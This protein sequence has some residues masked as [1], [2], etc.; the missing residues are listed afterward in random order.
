MSS[1]EAVIVVGSKKPRDEGGG[2]RE[3]R[4][5]SERDTRRNTHSLISCGFR[6]P[7]CVDFTSQTTMY[8][9]LDLKAMV[10]SRLDR[11]IL[12][13][14]DTEAQATMSTPQRLD[15][16]RPKRTPGGTPRR[17][18]PSSAAAPAYGVSSRNSLVKTPSPAGSS[19]TLDG[20]R[21]ASQQL[22]SSSPL[23]RS[24]LSTA[25]NAP[26]PVSLTSLDS[27]AKNSSPL[28]RS[29]L[30][31]H[32]QLLSPSTT[33]TTNNNNNNNNNNNRAYSRTTASP[34]HETTEP[35]PPPSSSRNNDDDD[36]VTQVPE[37]AELDEEMQ[38]AIQAV[39]QAHSSKISGLR[40][41]L[42]SADHGSSMAMHLLHAE[43]KLLQD[44]I[45]ADQAEID[46]LKKHNSKL[47]IQLSQSN[48]QGTNLP[49]GSILD[50]LSSTN[51]L[52]LRR[53][54]RT[55]APASRL[56]LLHLLLEAA[57]P[58]D[59]AAL[60]KY[61]EKIERS[62]RD[63]IGYLPDD[64]AVRC[65]LHLDLHSILRARLVSHRWNDVVTQSGLKLWRALALALT[66]K[67][68]EPPKPQQNTT[69]GWFELY[70]GLHY[71]EENWRKG[72][73]QRVVV[74][75]GH[76]GSIGAIKL[77]G[78]TLAT[79]SLD[80][81]LRIWNVR[82]SACLKIVKMPAPVS[83]LDFYG[84]YGPTGVI[85]AG[86]NDVGR[87]FLISMNGALLS[88]LSGHNKGI[89][90]LAMNSQYLVS[91]G[92]DKALVVW[93]W[94][95]GTRIVKFGQ[96][97]NPCAAISLFGST[98]SSVQVDGV[99]RCFN[100][101]SRELVSQ[102]KVQTAPERGV[103]KTASAEVFQWF[104]A[105]ARRVIIATKTRIYQLEYK[106]QSGTVGAGGCALVDLASPP[107]LVSL[108]P[109]THELNSGTL[110]VLKRRFAAAPRF[111]TRLGDDMRIFIGH[112]P[113]HAPPD[114][115]PCDR[116]I[117]GADQ[118]E[119]SSG[120]GSEDAL[121]PIGGAWLDTDAR[122]SSRNPTCMSLSSDQL[123]VGCSDGLL[124]AL[125]FCGT[126]YR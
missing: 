19:G 55:L 61:L 47:S 65:L 67:D 30:G 108:T 27:P 71:R 126:D 79:G 92:Y 117:N 96:Q 52:E 60:R 57:V 7:R 78:T 49:S 24:A 99:I 82:T 76:T 16:S 36:L 20:R 103:E 10:R 113:E 98:F 12:E 114:L 123:V 63:F 107:R 11:T 40:R 118:D 33:T 124:Y 28:T 95:E 94:R 41:V 38:A 119:N 45:A 120:C 35:T 26:R 56:H 112:L 51:D 18:L 77:R 54:F 84:Q 101:T 64:L 29:S 66:S 59:I 14:S 8:H 116:G 62:R 39:I 89:R 31:H 111:A 58:G 2:S 53:Y 72:L 90:T 48:P 104:V 5:I 15:P 17:S 74:L 110:D 106:L 1:L 50:I 25:N 21:R 85:A 68:D 69:E 122:V 46:R 22:Y 91:G 70:K 97:T 13:H 6:R 34:H 125:D 43:I 109:I 87:V 102:H 37:Q 9:R 93:N 86:G 73:A 81:T 3:K 4:E 23:S 83:S 80:G 32:R 121:Q 105:E 88:T 115:P 75:Q 44:K 42:S 100:I